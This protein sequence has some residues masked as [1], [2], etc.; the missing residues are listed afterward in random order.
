MTEQVGGK[1]TPQKVNA[2]PSIYTGVCVRQFPPDT[3]NGEINEFF[4]KNGL[5][6]DKIENVS[7]S[8]NGIATVK[9]IE[10]CNCLTL[11]DAIHQK[12]HFMKKMF[13]N[14]IVPLSPEK[15]AGAEPLQN[16]NKKE[17]NSSAQ[18]LEIQP[19]LSSSQPE[20]RSLKTTDTDWPSV[21]SLVR[22]H[23]LSLHNRI[24][25]FSLNLVPQTNDLKNSTVSLAAFNSCQS[26]ID[27]SSDENHT[28]VSPKVKKKSKR[29]RISSSKAEKSKRL[30]LSKSP[31]V[32]I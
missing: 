3:D 8:S 5:P 14:G 6:A 10:N 4:I 2:S 1:F 18:P 25:E 20:P 15:Q 22:R 19:A 27:S 28:K 31:S 7:I 9:D 13:C 23:S 24:P 30:N 12:M 32:K 26:T 29:S 11:I 21:P 17:E 16:I